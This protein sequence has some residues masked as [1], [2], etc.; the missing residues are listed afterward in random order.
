MGDV[1]LAIQRAEDKTAQMQARAGAIDE[2]IA[3]G[4]LDDASPPTP[5]DDITR[6]LEALSSQ[7]RRR[8]RAGPAQGR[9]PPRRPSRP[10]TTG[11]DILAEPSPSRRAEGESNEGSRMIV[12]ILGEGQYDARRR[13]ARRAQ[14]PRRR[15]SSRPS[16]PATR[17]AFAAALAALL[18]GVRATGAPHPSRLSSTSPT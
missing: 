4:A 2:L 17:R 15:R 14:R 7:L 16:R 13:R 11:G 3:S 18:Y 6:E 12:R 9:Q 10:P 8:G 5:G 1:G